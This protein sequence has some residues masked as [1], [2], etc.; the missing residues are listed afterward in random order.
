MDKIEQTQKAG[1]NA[2]QNQI[3]TQIIVGIDEKRVREICDEKVSIAIRDLSLGASDLARQRIDALTNKVIEKIKKDPS[4]IQAFSDPSFQRDIVRTQIAAAESDREP[5]IETLSELL[6]ARMNGK[7][8]RSTKTGLRKAIEIVPELEDEELTALAALLFCNRYSINN[9]RASHVDEYLA[10]LDGYFAKIFSTSS[11]PQGTR[12]LQHLGILDCVEV[13]PLG[14]FVKLEDYYTENFNGIVCVGITQGSPEH[15]EAAKIMDG[16]GLEADILVQNDL[17]PEYVRL[18][19][20]KLS[21]FSILPL[22][23]PNTVGINIIRPTEKQKEGLEKV[24]G[25]Y[26]KDNALLQNAKASF[27]KRMSRHGAIQQFSN[28]LASQQKSFGLTPIGEALAYVNVR[29][30]I[31][32][33]PI[34]E[35]E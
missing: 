20:V 19:I 30:C 24:I 31:P 7:L 23:I 29:R 11:L 1:D 18:P 15:I 28:W 16:F 14:P 12:W 10:R 21:D 32:E 8:K 5:D 6:L 25:L 27:V 35:L 3:G 17:L 22:S 34:I 33:L 13:N 26:Q 4:N 9:I 2:V